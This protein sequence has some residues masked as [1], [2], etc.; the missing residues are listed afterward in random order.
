MAQMTKDT[1][2]QPSIV[3]KWQGILDLLH[4]TALIPA[5]LIMR[6]R[7]PYIEV[8]VS[9]KN[10]NNPYH[11]GDKELVWNSGL[12]FETFIKMKEKLLVPDSL[13]DDKW[14][15]NPDVKLDMIAYLGFPLLFPDGSPF[16]TICVLDSKPNSYSSNIEKLM[17]QFR[18][19]IESHLEL[20]YFNQALG[21][22]N[23]RLSDY[24]EEL[25]ALRGIV[26]ICSNCKSIRD[27]KGAW[28][29]IEHYLIKTPAADFSHS[30]CPECIK[31]LYPEL[32][33]SG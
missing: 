17:A 20:L 27:E 31:R 4:E 23:K 25:Q 18:G 15:E 21:D 7:D 3:Q 29:P 28:K 14:K 8:F 32:D 11:P 5:A 22:K 30:I 24:L 13:A 16:G 6:L 9:S 26:P 1:E 12:Y 33:E 2:I 10:K 19:L